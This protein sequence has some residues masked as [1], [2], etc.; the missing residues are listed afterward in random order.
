MPY[1]QVAE[2]VAKREGCRSV[3]FTVP[4]CR[5]LLRYV[6]ERGTFVEEQPC[7]SE[8]TTQIVTSPGSNGTI[9]WKHAAIKVLLVKLL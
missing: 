3:P 4:D 8:Q 9:P 7:C 2:V 5:A 1:I 6:E